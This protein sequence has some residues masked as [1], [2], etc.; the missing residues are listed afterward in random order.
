[1]ARRVARGRTR[2]HGSKPRSLKI[3]SLGEKMS[4]LFTRIASKRAHVLVIGIGYVG[5][6]LVAEFVRA[7]YRTTGLD[8]EPAKVRLLNSGES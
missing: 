3:I 4:D 7:G 2:A 5:R 6:P 8:N 1:M